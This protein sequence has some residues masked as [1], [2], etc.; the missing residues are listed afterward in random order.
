MGLDHAQLHSLAP[1]ADPTSTRSLMSVLP[2]LL[3]G[4][5]E[6]G[7]EPRRVMFNLDD[8]PDTPPRVI[9]NGRVLN[10][11]GFCSQSK[12]FVR[13]WTPPG[14][15]DATWLYRRQID[16]GRDP[17]E[18]CGALPRRLPRAEC[19]A[20]AFAGPRTRLGA[21]VLVRQASTIVTAR[22]SCGNDTSPE[23]SGLLEFFGHAVRE[24]AVGV[25]AIVVGSVAI[26][27][28]MRLS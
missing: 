13:L 22:Q 10:L 23:G 27:G 3:T 28:V 6:G 12:S 4:L 17:I 18:E 11:G 14:E 24:R 2:N 25:Y 16:D 7:L 5:C 9:F 21:P 26:Y 8:W 20:T 19:H 15:T 1:H